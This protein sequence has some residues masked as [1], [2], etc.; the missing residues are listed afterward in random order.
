ME[1]NYE[2]INPNRQHKDRLFRLIF[3]D[4]KELLSLYNAM[5]QTNYTNPDDLQINT[6]ENAIYMSMHN[7]LSFLIDSSM[8][9]Y[10]HQ[11]TV[12]PNMPLRNLMYV[13]NLYSKITKDAN[14][15]GEKR[16]LIPTPEFVVFYNGV[17]EQPDKVTMR[18]SDA[19][20]K[21]PNEKSLEL[22]TTMLNINQG[23]NTELLA[24]CKTLRDYVQYADKVREYAVYMP[25]EEAVERAITECIEND[26]LADFLR[27]HKAEAKSV[28]IFE[29]D[30]EQHMRQ[31]RAE[32]HAEGRSEGEVL[33][34]I[35][36]I[37]KKTAKK[38]DVDT[39][40]EHLEE[41]LEFV[42]K[43]CSVI[44]E[45]P[46]SDTEDILKLLNQ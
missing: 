37:Q 13:S 22:V 27:N 33:K 9:L 46:R 1:E 38:L 20:E 29:Y 35:N 21:A 12:N 32:G 11:S 44:R 45:N 10:E 6:L 26:I 19:F 7:D 4:K 36:L 15:Y 2:P 23:H 28:S 31:V 30:E 18:L 17:K 41:P 3:R 24:N 5:N 34:V 8:T 14:L 39:I 43:V 25:L 16:I 42:E 40:A